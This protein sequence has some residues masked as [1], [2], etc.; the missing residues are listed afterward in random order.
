[1]AIIGMLFTNGLTEVSQS[2]E[3]STPAAD[4]DFGFKVLD[5]RDT[6]AKSTKLSPELVHGRRA[7]MAIFGMLFQNPATLQ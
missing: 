3:A 6:A 4:G 1:M 2:Q 7:M 5:S